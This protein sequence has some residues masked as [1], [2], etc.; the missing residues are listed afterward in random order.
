MIEKDVFINGP[1]NIVRLEGEVLS[2]QKTIK[3]TLYLFFDIHVDKTECIDIQSTNN[4]K[5]LYKNI[6]KQNKTHPKIK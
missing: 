4:E 6:D 3:K 1:I 5:Y 2:N